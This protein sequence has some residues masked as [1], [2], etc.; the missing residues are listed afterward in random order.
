MKACA[1]STCCA[2]AGIARASVV[3]DVVALAERVAF[4]HDRYGQGAIAEEF[5]DGRELTLRRCSIRQVFLH[6]RSDTTI[7]DL[8]RRTDGVI[9]ELFSQLR[10]GV[11]VLRT[12]ALLR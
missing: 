12:P 4:I 3:Q 9:I 6:D 1:S 2:S 7:E 11:A 10:S 8:I 5:V